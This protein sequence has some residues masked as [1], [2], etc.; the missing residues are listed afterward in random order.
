ML[1]THGENTGNVI[2]TRLLDLFQFV[3][4]FIDAKEGMTPTMREGITDHIWTWREFLTYHFQ[5]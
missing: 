4:N 2:H 5:L 1:C 3:S